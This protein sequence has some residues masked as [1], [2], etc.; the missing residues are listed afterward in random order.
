MKKRLIVIVSLAFL[1]FII[2]FIFYVCT[3][4]G[5]ISQNQENWS[6]FG[7]Y[8]SGITGS[9]FSFL[10]FI[11]VVINLN[12]QI[13]EIKKAQLETDKLRTAEHIEKEKTELVQVVGIISKE[14]EEKLGS[15]NNNIQSVGRANVSSFPVFEEL[16]FLFKYLKECNSKLSALDNDMTII[17]FYKKRYE[18]YCKEMNRRGILEFDSL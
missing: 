3:F 8:L 5:G 18:K 6:Q 2:P 12:L 15:Y 11:A 9:I 14:I 10:S 1:G 17:I 4:P 16:A 7:S 13:D